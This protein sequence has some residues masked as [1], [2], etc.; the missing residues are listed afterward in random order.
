MAKLTEVGIEVFLSMICPEVALLLQKWVSENV[1]PE[2][3]E[4]ARNV[5]HEVI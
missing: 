4:L 2:I 5:T 3:E 1:S